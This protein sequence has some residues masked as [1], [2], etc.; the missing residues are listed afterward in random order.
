MLSQSAGKSLPGTVQPFLSAS[1]RGTAC[2]DQFGETNLYA[3]Q[4]KR[5]V[6]ASLAVA[7]IVDYLSPLFASENSSNALAE[8]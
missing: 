8:G 4:I 3:L 2:P 6:I 7:G 5:R 1:L